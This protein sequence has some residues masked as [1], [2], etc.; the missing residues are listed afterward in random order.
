MTS[1]LAPLRIL[2]ARSLPIS[3]IPKKALTF[4]TDWSK[5][6]SQGT[7]KTGTSFS[8]TKPSGTTRLKWRTLPSVTLKSRVSVAAAKVIIHPLQ[9]RTNI[10]R[11]FP[12]M[13]SSTNSCSHASTSVE[14]AKRLPVSL[15]SEVT[16]L[17]CPSKIIQFEGAPLATLFDSQKDSAKGHSVSPHLE[18]ED[19]QIVD[20]AEFLVVSFHL[21]RSCAP[22]RQL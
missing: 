21:N 13:V 12:R 6:P 20:F 5:N 2:N 9:W 15:A 17:A 19:N 10:W 14:T 7:S 1:S 16:R 8:S 18:V 11:H 22:T 3:P 4:Q